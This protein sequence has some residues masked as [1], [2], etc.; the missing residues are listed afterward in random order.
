MAG[1]FPSLKGLVPSKHL[2]IDIFC[3]AKKRA[4]EDNFDD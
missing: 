3:N 1:K 4:F 2:I